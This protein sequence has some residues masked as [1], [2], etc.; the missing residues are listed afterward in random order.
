MKEIR[1]GCAGVDLV[2]ASEFVAVGA[3]AGAS[4]GECAPA[5]AA[6]MDMVDG[7]AMCLLVGCLLLV[8][9]ILTEEW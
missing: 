5:W 4:A 8:W 2:V 9:T 6:V 1:D 7:L 3:S